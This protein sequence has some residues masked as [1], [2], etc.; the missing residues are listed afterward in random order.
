[1]TGISKGAKPKLKRDEEAEIDTEEEKYKKLS[2]YNAGGLN[3]NQWQIQDESDDM[4]NFI[5]EQFD[6]NHENLLNYQNNP[7]DQQPLSVEKSTKVRK[8][9]E[10]KE[11]PLYIE[12]ELNNEEEEEVKSPDLLEQR[13]NSQFSLPISSDNIETNFSYQR[14]ESQRK[15]ER[16]PF[17]PPFKVQNPQLNS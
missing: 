17:S 7:D 10:F 15:E 9:K 13:K 2:N 1:M 4:N 11:N 6:I 3:I 5:E 12:F 16:R 8:S 14:L